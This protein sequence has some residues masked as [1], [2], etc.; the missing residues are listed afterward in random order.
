MEVNND[1]KQISPVFR[2]VPVSPGVIFSVESSFSRSAYSGD[3]PKTATH[4]LNS[5]TVWERCD[6]EWTDRHI[7]LVLDVNCLSTVHHDT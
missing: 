3:H 6:D 7:R 1:T 5:H 2:V 4:L